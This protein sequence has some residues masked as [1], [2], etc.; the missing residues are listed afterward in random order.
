MKK[1]HLYFKVIGDII[2]NDDD[3]LCW[4]NILKEGLPQ[5]QILKSEKLRVVKS[6]IA[7]NFFISLCPDI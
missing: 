2:L 1:I 3:S 4:G 7:V 5:A 6:I